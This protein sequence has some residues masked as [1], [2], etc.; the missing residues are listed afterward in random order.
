[1]ILSKNH[2]R[3]SGL[4]I[5]RIM[6][7]NKIR[8]VTVI[9][10]YVFNVS[11]HVLV[12]VLGGVVFYSGLRS[13]MSL[14]T[15]WSFLFSNSK[16]W[17]SARRFFIRLVMLCCSLM[18]LASRLAVGDSV[19]KVFFWYAILIAFLPVWPLAQLVKSNGSCCWVQKY[20][21]ALRTK[22]S[23][24]NVFVKAEGKDADCIYCWSLAETRGCGDVWEKGL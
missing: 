12:R 22:I 18:S 4:K 2:S 9:L 17:I 24:G 21:C 3:S 6:S 13:M 11:L 8:S 10:R 14:T 23:D 19:L 20:S 5:I 7:A 16:L 15:I 1:M